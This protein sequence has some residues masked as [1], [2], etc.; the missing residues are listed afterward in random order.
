MRSA[1]LILILLISFWQL[2]YTSHPFHASITEC[3]YNDETKG[4]EITLRLFTDDLSQAIDM[5][6]SEGDK[7]SDD[8]NAK[9]KEYLLSNFSLTTK[10]GQALAI[11]YIGLERDFDIS[12]AYFEIESFPLLSEY[13]ISQTVFF[14]Q[15]NDQTNILNLKIRKNTFSDYFTPSK[16]TKTYSV[17]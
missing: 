3:N 14:D 4:L 5:E 6:I 13:Q 1:K 16:I 11:Q 7:I 12:F 8:L 15:F 2:A 17:Q 10:E 9:I